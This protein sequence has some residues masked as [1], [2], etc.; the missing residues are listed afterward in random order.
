MSGPIVLAAGQVQEPVWERLSPHGRVVVAENDDEATLIRLAHEAVALIARGP[1]RITAAVIDAA[2]R[3]RVIGRTG[4]G[5]DAVDLAAATSRGIPVVIT[6][7]ANDAAVAEG[8][9][10]MLLSLIKRLPQFDR[11]VREGD[12]ASRDGTP[13]GDWA[14]STLAIVGL[15]RIGCR[16]AQLAALLG[17]RVVAYDPLLDAAPPGVAVT[18]LDL[19]DALTEA[20]H[21]TLHTPLTRETAGLVTAARLAVARPGLRLV[22][23]SR[24]GVA[25]LDELVTALEVGTLGGVALDVYDTEPPDLGHPLF[26]RSDVLCA[27]HVL[28]LSAAARSAVFTSMTEGM[29]QVLEGGRPLHVANPEALA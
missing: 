25:P 26:A 3:L 5:T 12:W 19:D 7:G 20:D 8:T 13:P 18:L 1:S 23:T 6:P 22:N 16:V 24:G 21:V 10:A 9:I 27:P 4:V 14:G 15:G 17:M 11:A 28:G 29:V 2:P